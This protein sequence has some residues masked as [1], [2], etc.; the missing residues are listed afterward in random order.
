MGNLNQGPN[1][2]HAEAHGAQTDLE[3]VIAATVPRYYANPVEWLDPLI[4]FFRPQLSD[5]RITER[6]SDDRRCS[7]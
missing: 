4:D 5:G 2:P 1:G 3:E 6:R 7:A